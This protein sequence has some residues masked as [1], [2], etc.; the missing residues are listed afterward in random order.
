M[1]IISHSELDGFCNPVSNIFASLVN[2]IM[3]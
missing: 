1:M 3:A 2:P